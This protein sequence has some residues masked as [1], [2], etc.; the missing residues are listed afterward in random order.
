M[1]VLATTGFLQ[2]LSEKTLSGDICW[3]CLSDLQQI[4]IEQN[5]SLY[6]A[7]MQNE[8]HRI[9]IYNSFFCELPSS[10]FVYLIDES[11]ESGKFNCSSSGLNV[12]I[13]KDFSA[14][15]HKLNVA[16][17]FVYQLQNAIL[18]VY[19]ES[20]SEVQAFIDNFFK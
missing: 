5:K 15:M 7:I 14:K 11:F 10:G 18:S 9:N 17:Q 12:Y 16:L 13:Q 6:F 8:Y 4:T 20:D 2:T 19:S 1:N 3:E